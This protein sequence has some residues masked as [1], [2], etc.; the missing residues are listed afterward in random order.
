MYKKFGIS[1]YMK[2]LTLAFLIIAGTILLGFRPVSAKDELSFEKSKY[3]LYEGNRTSLSLVMNGEENFQ[4]TSEFL[5][6][7][8]FSTSDES[9]VY[10]D[11]FGNI[12]CRATGKATI[13]AQY[14]GMSC[15][16]TVKVNKSKLKL[17][18]YEETLYSH[19]QLILRVSGIKNIQSIWSTYECIG[20]ECDAVWSWEDS[21]SVT[22]YNS[23]SVIITAGRSGD[24]RI[25]IIAE[26]TSG[27]TY[28]KI[29]TLHTINA[30][31]ERTEM[32]VAVGGEMEIG[33]INSEILSVE[34][35]KWYEGNYEIT[36][37]ER[38]ESEC[39]IESDGVGGFTASGET[40]AVYEL[41]YQADDGT[42][43][44]YPLM[45]TSYNPQ[46]IPFDDYLWVGS[47]YEPQFLDKRWTSVV[48]CTS[49]DPSV[50]SIN[51]TGEIVPMGGGKA[52]LTIWI[53]GV[54]F[55]DEVE[56]IDAHISSNNILT[57]PGTK[58]SFAVSG[59]PEGMK[60]TYFSSDESV[61]TISK[62][63]KLKVKKTGFTMI[64]VKINN[65][66]FYYTVNVGNEIP[67]KACLAAAEVVGKATYSQD[68]RMEEGFYDCSS[69]AWRSYAKAGLKIKNDSYAPTAADLAEYL[70][71]NGCTIAYECLPV[72][73][74]LPG[75]LL[76]YSSGGDNGRYKR[77]DHVALY[78]STEDLVDYGDGLTGY[79]RIVHAGS[80]GGGVYFSNYPAYGNVVLIARIKEK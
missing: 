80:G 69:L 56:V 38:D 75:D 28:S 58:F 60:V 44:T 73:D 72:E 79:G 55:T 15:K 23:G 31:P 63:G 49:S 19:Q 34:L 5:N 62:K 52:E 26:T 4:M 47:S 29:F 21:P 30:G 37:G 13:T 70:N 61:A 8:C 66:D 10:V 1:G 53:D 9:I 25:R 50:V 65:T 42:I 59:I 36:P 17:S 22:S 20:N 11:Y 43:L 76:F 3:T 33:M 40:T 64:T 57:W 67:V 24:Y 6:A 18:Y 71:D 32:S 39:P 74:M 45:V 7:G 27:Q 12:E 2:L 78:Y 54:E 48:N 77:I 51:T 35:L 14:N 68:K 41:T 16:C 46:Y